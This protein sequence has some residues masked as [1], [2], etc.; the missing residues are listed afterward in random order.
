[1]KADLLADK[2]LHHA[3]GHE[4]ASYIFDAVETGHALYL[5]R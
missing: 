4:Y 2:P 1:M 3:R 5:W